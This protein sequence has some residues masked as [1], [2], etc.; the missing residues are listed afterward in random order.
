L[1]PVRRTSHRS[2]SGSSPGSSSDSLENVRSTFS[3]KMKNR[4]GKKMV[5][6]NAKNNN[7]NTIVKSKSTPNMKKFQVVEDEETVQKKQGRAARFQKDFKK[8]ASFNTFNNIPKGDSPMDEEGDMNFH[9]NGYC[10]DL[11]KPYLRLTSAPDPS[12]VRPVDVLEKSLNH[13]KEHWKKKNDY[14]FACEQM[15]SIRQDLTVQGIQNEFTATVYEC[16]ARIALEKGDREEF[17]QCQTCLRRLYNKGISGEVAEFT[18]YSILYYIFT[19]SNSDLNSCLS[20]L[21]KDLK[22]EETVQHAL[23]FRSAWALSNYRLF[24]K[25]YLTAPKMGGYLVDLFIDR[26]RKEA[27]KRMVKA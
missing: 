6:G 2:S 3:N 25:L 16:H 10:K 4:L 23:A 7:N 26:E 20:S 18:A 13:V 19:K 9:I 14:H 1:S 17:N 15:K 24:F 21:T 11:T 8:S 12:T 27:F 22:K 5:A